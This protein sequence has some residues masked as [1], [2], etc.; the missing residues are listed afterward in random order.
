M[1]RIIN[2]NSASGLVS[3]EE[4]VNVLLERN[5]AGF[6]KRRLTRREMEIIAQNEAEKDRSDPFTFGR[7]MC[8]L[9]NGVF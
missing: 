5:K 4:Q 6:I 8:H 3:R 7:T 1:T 9:R 2:F